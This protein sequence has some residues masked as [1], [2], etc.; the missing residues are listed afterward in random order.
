[1]YIKILYYTKTVENNSVVETRK[2]DGY[3]SVD[4]IETVLNKPGR[5]IERK[6]CMLMHKSATLYRNHIRIHAQ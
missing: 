3:C 6:Y 2:A 4:C 5:N 1:M